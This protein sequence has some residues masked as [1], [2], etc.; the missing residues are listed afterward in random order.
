MKKGFIMMRLPVEALPAFLAVAEHLSF[1]AAAAK[2]GMSPSA[3]SQIVRG[4]E[5]RVGTALFSRTTRS[6]ALTEAGVMFLKQVRPAMAEIDA[7]FSM[8]GNYATRPSGLLRINASTGILPFLLPPLEQFLAEN[9]GV[10]AELFA[11]DGLT[12]IVGEG[13]DAGIRVGEMLQPDMIAVRLSPPFRF[14]VAATP[15][16]LDAMP[17]PE[18]PEELARHRCIRFRMTSSGRIAPWN[19]EW[20]GQTFAVMVNGRLVVNDTPT[21]IAAALKGLGLIQV[22]DPLIVDHVA[23]GQLR[24]VLDDFST[25][26]PGVFLYYPRR[27]ALVPKLRAFIDFVRGYRLAPRSATVAGEILSRA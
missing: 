9:S 4:L 25:Q 19:F 12:D 27:N 16:Y 15:E 5:D 8:L 17:A 7:S 2:L 1:T 26:T 21:M 22:A 24:T 6:V 20:E 3:V 11:D 10:E 14:S 13:F 18:R 23:A